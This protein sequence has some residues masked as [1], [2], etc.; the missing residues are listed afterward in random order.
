MKKK[1]EPDINQ[2]FLYDQLGPRNLEMQ[3]MV[4]SS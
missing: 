1:F 2:T 4:Q 3:K